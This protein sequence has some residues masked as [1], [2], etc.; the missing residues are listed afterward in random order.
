MET[1]DQRV[2]APVVE[3]VVVHAHALAVRKKR[4]KKL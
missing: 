2:A 1:C 4:A 3:D